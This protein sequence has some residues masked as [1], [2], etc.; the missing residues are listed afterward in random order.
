M[1]TIDDITMV[2]RAE[3]LFVSALPTGAPVGLSELDRAIAEA[4]L[5]RG[6]AAGCA[7][8]MANAYGDN[9]RYAAERMRWALRVLRE[10]PGRSAGSAR[11]VA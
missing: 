5:A 4:M 6:G 9:P 2:D 8:E 7:A 1:L 10:A 3:A 11:E